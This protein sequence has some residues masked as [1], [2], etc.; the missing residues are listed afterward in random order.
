MQPTIDGVNGAV[1]EEPPSK[2]IRVARRGVAAGLISLALYLILATYA[3]M[4]GWEHN[5]QVAFAR[6]A[7]TLGMVAGLG[8]ALYGYGVERSERNC[9]AANAAML[10]RFR[11]ALAEVEVDR[12]R[13]EHRHADRLAETL[14]GEL[15]EVMARERTILRFRT[16]D[17]PRPV[18]EVPRQYRVRRS[19]QADVRGGRGR[20]SA[21]EA[22]KRLAERLD[23]DPGER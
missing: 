4:T 19:R 11:G 2:N 22:L 1:A 14:A 15:A 3:A 7:L 18:A 6:S 12:V 20:K 23:N 21:I 5:E 8:L 13:R 9:A 16:Q 17:A 10:E